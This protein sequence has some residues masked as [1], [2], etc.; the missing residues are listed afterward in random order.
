LTDAPAVW[1]ACSASRGDEHPQLH[2]EELTEMRQAD[3]FTG[4]DAI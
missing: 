1:F 4:Y 3:A 2:L